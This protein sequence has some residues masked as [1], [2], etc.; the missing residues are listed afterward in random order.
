VSQSCGARRKVRAPDGASGAVLAVAGIGNP[1]QF[2]EGLGEA[3]LDVAATRAFRD[4]HRY[5]VADV[6]AIADAARA[7]GVDGVI[8]TAKDAVRFEPLG[9]LP[10]ALSVATVTLEFDPPDTL[11]ASLEAALER[12]RTTA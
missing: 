7:A 1:S 5:T 12:A 10:F 11:F 8:T 3:G 2:F 9:P 6:R 4:H